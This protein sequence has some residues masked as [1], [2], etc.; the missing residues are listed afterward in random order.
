MSHPSNVGTPSCREPCRRGMCRPRGCLA[1]Y[2]CREAISL[3]RLFSASRLS[4]VD[5][6][7]R[8]SKFSSK[9][10]RA[11]GPYPDG[12]ANKWFWSMFYYH[13]IKR[14]KSVFNNVF[15]VDCRTDLKAGAILITG[16]GRGRTPI[17]RTAR[18][19]KKIRHLEIKLIQF[20]R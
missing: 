19:H 7:D 6:L 18:K 13:T 5:N 14:V 17:F 1:L 10:P 15:W 9:I 2:R 11:N 8:R 3:S 16:R 20:I 12:N 4:S